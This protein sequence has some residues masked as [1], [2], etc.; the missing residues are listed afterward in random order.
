MT[1]ERAQRDREGFGERQSLRGVWDN[2]HWNIKQQQQKR[3]YW[4]II[5][6]QKKLW[7]VFVIRE[8]NGKKVVKFITE[9]SPNSN[10]KW[11]ILVLQVWKSFSFLSVSFFIFLFLLRAISKPELLLT[12]KGIS[13]WDSLSFFLCRYYLFLQDRAIVLPVS[14]VLIISAGVFI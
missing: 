11:Y 7:N 5:H 13:L 8:R 9:C 1:S 10:K 6:T 14:F 4:S 12:M 2:Y 3:L